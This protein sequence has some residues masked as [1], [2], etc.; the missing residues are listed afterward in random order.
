MKRLWQQAR[1]RPGGAKLLVLM[2]AALMLFAAACGGGTAGG[3]TTTAAAQAAATTAAAAADTTT[4]AAAPPADEPV[5]IS[6]RGKPKENDTATLALIETRTADMKA[7]HPNVT[8]EYIDWSYD[9]NTFLP[10]AASGQLPTL[11]NTYFTEANKIISQGFSL[12]ITD[13]V[14]EWGYDTALNPSMLELISKDGRIYGLPSAGYA[15]GMGYNVEL[16][17][18]AGLLNEDGTP[19]LPTTTDELTQTA[20][21]IKEATG[22]AGFFF[23]TMNNQGGWFFTQLAWV[24]GAEF[25]EQD[26]DGKYKAVFNS[27]EAVEALQWLKDMQWVHGVMQPNVMVT[28]EEITKLF[29]VDQCGTSIYELGQVNTSIVNYTANKDHFAM[30]PIV[31]GSNAKGRQTALLGGTFECIAP[32]ATPAQVQAVLQFLEVEGYSPKLEEAVLAAKE[33]QWKVDAENNK[34]VGPQGIRVWV[35]KARM[36]AEDERIAKYTNVDMKLFTPFTDSLNDGSYPLHP[37]HPVYCQELYKALDSCV[38]AVLTD[39]NADPQALMDTAVADF[40]RDYLDKFNAGE[41]AN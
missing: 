37:E 27:P 1:K 16:F 28:F 7:R 17:K 38:Q 14:K 12:D 5:T 26:A 20:I 6:V 23:P 24:F 32:N 15:L 4:T 35:D 39:K 30:G 36:D 19:I 13:A 41:E 8:L 34:M 33:E 9:V 29:A 10:K 11:Y 2:L 25:E 31:K 22:Q 21:K 18:Q 3:A 40:Q